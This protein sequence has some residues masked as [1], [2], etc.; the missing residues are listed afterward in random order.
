MG[1][2]AVRNTTITYTTATEPVPCVCWHMRN[3]SVENTRIFKLPGYTGVCPVVK[4]VP[5]RTTLPEII[6]FHTLNYT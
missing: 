4:R 5:L 2:L 3:N 1:K 6:I